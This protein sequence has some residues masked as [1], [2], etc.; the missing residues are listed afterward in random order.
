MKVT[1]VSADLL[2]KVALGGAVIFA[3]YYFAK[4]A[5]GAA[6]EALGAAGQAILH[7]F[8]EFDNWVQSKI[9]SVFGGGAAAPTTTAKLPVEFGVIDPGADW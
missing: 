4:K 9:D 7:P 8:P 6:G 2:V 5:T 1:P 3:A